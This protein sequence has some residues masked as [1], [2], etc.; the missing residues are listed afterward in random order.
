[1]DLKSS[2]SGQQKTPNSV[3][4]VSLRD[5]NDTL[6]SELFEEFNFLC[7]FVFGRKF[8]FLKNSAAFVICE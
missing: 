4:A 3:C 7:L 2:R 5:N 6:E 8:L 1:M